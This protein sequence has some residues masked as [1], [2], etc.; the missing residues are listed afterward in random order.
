MVLVTTYAVGV[1][2]ASP[3]FSPLMVSLWP[4]MVTVYDEADVVCEAFQP[5]VT[6]F[7]PGRLAVASGI[8]RQGLPSPLG[9]QCRG[10][11]P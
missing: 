5:V 11:A 10:S 7:G 9:D 3:K 6:G 4:V 8:E 2:V 1:V